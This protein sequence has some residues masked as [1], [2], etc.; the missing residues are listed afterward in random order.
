MFNCGWSMLIMIFTIQ[1]RLQNHDEPT[2]VLVPLDDP[3]E[4]IATL[5]PLSPDAAAMLMDLTEARPLIRTEPSV[6]TPNGGQQISGLVDCAATLDFV[7]K[8]FV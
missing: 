7:S 5:R 1:P 8:D 6:K 2:L 3:M 4:H